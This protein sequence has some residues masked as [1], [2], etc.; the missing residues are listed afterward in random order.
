MDEVCVEVD[1]EIKSLWLC[2]TGVCKMKQMI[3]SR[4]DPR[5]DVGCVVEERDAV[6]EYSDVCDAYWSVEPD[7]CEARRALGLEIAGE[8]ERHTQV[9]CPK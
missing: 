6:W 9:T 5:N 7:S 4:L 3:I 1:I 8:E 2:E